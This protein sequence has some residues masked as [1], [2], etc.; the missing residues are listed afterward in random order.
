MQDPTYN[1]LQL[2]LGMLLTTIICKIPHILPVDLVVKRNRINLA[3]KCVCCEDPGEES[4]SHLF[5]HSQL[6]VSLWDFFGSVFAIRHQP[7]TSLLARITWWFHACRGSS[8]FAIQGR[9][10]AIAICRQIW[11]F[12]NNIIYGGMR[13]PFSHARLVVIDTLQFVDHLVLP[14]IDSS[15][16]GRDSLEMIGIVQRGPPLSR[17][18]RGDW[19][20]PVTGRHSLHIAGL[21]SS[22]GAIVSGIV[23]DH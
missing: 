10:A 15:M 9:M 12:R 1:L 2:Y 8:H 3:S 14:G 7:S 17:M 13:K 22:T 20:P 11:S 19:S 5:L 23:R 18:R 21:S 16:F 6:A 4:L